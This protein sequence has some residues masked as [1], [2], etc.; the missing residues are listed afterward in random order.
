[1]LEHRCIRLFTL[2]PHLGI[3]VSPPF[4]PFPYL[5][6]VGRTVKGSLCVRNTSA[7]FYGLGRFLLNTF[8]PSFNVFV[9]L[10]SLILQALVRLAS[11]E[12]WFFVRS[13]HG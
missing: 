10:D 4:K 5:P 12:S 13:R 8:A 3:V 6:I 7:L 2:G 9:S 1:L 11:T